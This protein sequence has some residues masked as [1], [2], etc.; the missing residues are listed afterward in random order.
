MSTA[1]SRLN[2]IL[3]TVPIKLYAISEEAV[4]QKPD[5]KKW[6]KKEILGHLI[7]SACNNHQRF[8]RL[9]TDNDIHFPGYNQD[10]W[11]TVERWQLKRWDEIIAFWLLYNEHILH[12]FRHMDA[13][14]L[15]NTVTL[16]EEIFTLQF[17]IDDYVDHMEH[18]LRQIL[19]V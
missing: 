12:L 17:L 4:S 18:H 16:G 13:T 14:K 7:D 9:Q 2:E 8:I 15:F 1:Y 5:A 3:A 11:V 10:D 6:S 19:P